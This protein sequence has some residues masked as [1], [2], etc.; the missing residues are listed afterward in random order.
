MS[1]DSNLVPLSIRRGGGD[2]N[3]TGTCFRGQ[4]ANGMLSSNTNHPPYTGEYDPDGDLALFNNGQDPNG[5]WFLVVTDMAGS[6]TGSVQGFSITFGNNPTPHGIVPCDVHNAMMCQCPDGTQDCDL[7][8]DMTA[9]AA[10]LLNGSY[11]SHDTIFINNATPNIGWGPLEIHGIN[12]C[13]CDTVQ[14]SC[15]TSVCPDGNPP[16]QLVEQTI[17]HKDTA[18]MT[19][20]NRPAGTMTYH[21][22]HGHIHLDGWASYTLRQAEYG[23]DPPD[24]PVVGTGNKMSYCLV[25][26]GTCTTGNGY[27]VDTNGTILSQPDFPNF[28]LGSVT[29]C[30]T[31]QGIFVGNLDVY[32]QALFGQWITLD[33]VCN[34]DYYVV[35]ITDPNNLILETNENNNWAAVPFTL[36]QQLNLPFPSV[37]FTYSALANTVTFTNASTDFDSL[38]WDFGDGQRDT[39]SNPVHTYSSTGTFDVVLTAYNRCGFK[40]QVQSF[41]ITTSG[42]STAGTASLFGVKVY[43]NPT[44][45]KINI[46]F[47]LSVRIPVQIQLLDILGN[48]VIR[49]E[50]SIL[51]MGSHHYTADLS[52][53]AGGPGIY[54]VRVVTG[55]KVICKRISYVK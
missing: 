38:E 28:G 22:Q 9:S 10:A 12:S 3:F 26:L 42:I 6:D 45:Y 49:L 29:G 48:E 47:G 15:T 41:T 51:D 17:Y 52:S 34:G 39:S 16:R 21:P 50:D 19:S 13:W 36:Q 8:P 1:P 7:L 53:L 2:N 27:C 55:N 44:T 24:W 30:S 4:G 33:S 40:Q 32:S 20:Y 46:D 43:P 35:S 18:T 54:L 31:D 25:N 23:V 14:V 37:N 5:T 11:E